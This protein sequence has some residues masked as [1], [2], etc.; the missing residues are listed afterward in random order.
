MARADTCLL[1]QAVAYAVDKSN[2]S[3][4]ELSHRHQVR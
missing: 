1:D 3:L 4:P 2:S